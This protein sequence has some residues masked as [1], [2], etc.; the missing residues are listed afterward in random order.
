M[1]A[2]HICRIANQFQRITDRSA[3]GTVLKSKTIARVAGASR[4]D[5]KAVMNTKG[6]PGA[7][8]AIGKEDIGLGI[9]DSPPPHMDGDTEAG[10]RAESPLPGLALPGAS[11]ESMERMEQGDR[12]DATKTVISRNL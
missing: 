6:T 12:T 1:A 10:H 3:H 9:D 11:D 2:R 5:V 8:I 7:R 4:W